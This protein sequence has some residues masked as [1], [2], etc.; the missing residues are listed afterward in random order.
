[1]SLLIVTNVTKVLS[2]HIVTDN[3]N[4][5]DWCSD[6]DEMLMPLNG[7]EKDICINYP[8]MLPYFEYLTEMDINQN[9]VIIQVL[10]KDNKGMNPEIFDLFKRMV[11]QVELYNGDA[12]YLSMAEEGKTYENMG[13]LK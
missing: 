6:Q 8:E 4:F 9:K 1:M 2:L 7:T 5:F 10:D 12:V 11:A 3:K 13:V